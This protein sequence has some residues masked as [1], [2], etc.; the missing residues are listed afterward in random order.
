MNSFPHPNDLN[1]NQP[2]Q[3]PY[4][5]QI[6]DIIELQPG[7]Q[8]F[9]DDYLWE[10]HR[11]SMS[12]CYHQP[13]KFSGNPILWPETA[14]ETDPR[15]PP[16]AIAKSGGV[17]FDDRYQLFKM[18]YMTG[19]LGYAA[20]AISR[21]G[22]HWERPSLDIVPGT[23]LILP[24]EV[25]PDSGSVIIDHNATGDEP[26]YK[27]LMREP[28]P[29]GPP[30]I[31][32]FEALLYTSKDGVH[33]DFRGKSGPMDDRSTMYYNPIRQKWV[34]SIRK[35][36]PLACRARYYHEGDHFLESARWTEESMTPW[37]RADCLDHG[38][39]FPAQL[40]NF[41]AIAYESMMIGFHQILHGP[42]NPHGE[43]RG[44]PKLTELYLSSSRDGC[45]WYRPDR[46]PFIPA[47]REYGSWEFGY[48]ESSAGMCCIVGDEL[49]LYYSAYGG[50]PNRITE[51]WRTNGM[52]SNG[53]MGL[54]KIRRDGFAS[55]RPN[56]PGSEL[57]TRRM[58]FKGRHLFV[59]A[60]TVGSRL[61]VAAIGT[62]EKP[63]PGL[64]HEDCLGFVGNST[65]AQI[66]WKNKDLYSLE[67]E[68]VRFHFKLD[69]GDL[70]SF[71]M[72][73]NLEGKSG[74]FTAAGGPGYTN[75]RDT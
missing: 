69:R 11:T 38:K 65:C 72:T 55:M 56:Y 15:F 7:R 61:S 59:N 44:E 2:I 8:L 37:M 24:Q 50:D 52:Y 74:G 66:R 45:H 28:N 27:M 70:F 36:H 60:T 19:Y 48:V 18:W 20:L 1:N 17:W 33:W 39:Y 49:W 22:I 23:N 13:A 67:E 30:W 64:S 53:A 12:P 6:P 35:W 42:N 43:S 25:H 31:D 62:D 29:V 26:R 47:R 68:G 54:A 10:A 21:D 14:E 9:L 73:D 4:L 57:Q 51:D 75:G 58:R 71:W 5:K 3:V 46:Q 34:Q 41:D 32:N 40:Y 63:I 16:C